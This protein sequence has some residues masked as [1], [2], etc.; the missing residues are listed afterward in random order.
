VLFGACSPDEGTADRAPDGATPQRIGPDE[1]LEDTTDPELE[2]GDHGEE[3]V[4]PPDLAPDL[5]VEVRLREVAVL[6]A[7]TAGTAG[8]DG[9]LYLAERS[10]TVHPLEDGRLG[11]AVVDLTDETTTDGERGLLGLAFAAD[12]S[13]LFLS[14]TDRD[15]DSVVAAVPVVDGRPRDGQRRV[16]LTV[17]QPF[18]N[19]N[20]GDLRLGPDGLLYLGLGDGGGAGDPQEHGQDRS[21]PLGAILRL[22]PSRPDAIPADNPHVG[23]PDGHDAVWVHGLRNPWRFSF[24]R[25]TGALYVADVGQGSREEVSVLAFGDAAGANLGWNRMEGTRPFA[26]EE[27]DDHVPPVHQYVTRE[28]GCA[29]TGGFVYRG[30]AIPSL[31]GAYLF[32]DLCVSTLRAIVVA[33][34]E[35][36]DQGVLSVTGSEITQVVSFVE[37]ADGELYLVSLNGPVLRLEPA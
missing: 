12:G 32:S 25:V 37:D 4:L 2:A 6:R 15:G 23:D 1:P 31:V 11:D 27:P 19:H 18:A 13:E 34:G 33:D 14:Y 30:S 21:T 16:L 24:D 26:G 5:A 35:V 9:T 8:P 36:V 17:E 10:G 28:E 22:D 7:P 20:G 29:V 3:P